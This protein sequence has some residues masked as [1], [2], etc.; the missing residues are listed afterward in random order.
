[1]KIIIKTPNL[2]LAKMLTNLNI[3]T[4]LSS[5]VF[6]MSPTDINLKDNN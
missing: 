1:M 2:P 6:M 5:L 3:L 4:D